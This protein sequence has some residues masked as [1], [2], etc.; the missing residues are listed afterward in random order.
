MCGG[1]LRRS[2]RVVDRK[3]AALLNLD[4]PS[5]EEREK[6]TLKRSVNSRLVFTLF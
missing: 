4:S 5:S 3:V 2:A 6:K 1:K